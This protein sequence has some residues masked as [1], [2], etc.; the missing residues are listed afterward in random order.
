MRKK[1]FCML[2]VC[3]LSVSWGGSCIAASYTIT[4]AELTRL[5]TIFEQLKIN[6]QKLQT[7][8]AESKVNLLTAKNKLD[9]SQKQ[10]ETLQIQLS[11]LR[12]ESS[13][14][15]AESMKAQD[16]LAK[17]NQSLQEYEREVKGQIKSLT[18]QRNLLG[19]LVI[20]AAVRK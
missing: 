6:N 10:L 4:D 11:Q 19:I 13:K 9:E 2:L 16:S 5:E 17:A 15:K 20:V 7:D 18:W 1:L 8:L 12:E 14:A 3:L